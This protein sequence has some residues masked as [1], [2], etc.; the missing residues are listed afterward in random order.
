VCEEFAAH[1]QAK[2]TIWMEPPWKMLLSNKGILP[3]MWDLFPNHPNL[4]EASFDAPRNCARWVRKPLLGREGANVTIHSDEGDVETDGDYGSEGFI[5]QD[6]A[7][8]VSFDGKYPVVGS[9]VI[10][11]EEG[12]AAAGVGIR[13]SDTPIVTNT[14]QF[15]PHLFS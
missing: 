8:L 5:Y 3:M 10:G 1:L 6:V 13:E 7:P 14:S 2:G 15:V 12:D 9:W 4:L 11:H